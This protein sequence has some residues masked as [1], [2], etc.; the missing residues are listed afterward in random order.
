MTTIRR[1]RTVAVQADANPDLLIIQARGGDGAA[2]GTLLDLYRNYLRLV[3][4]SMMGAALRV[5]LEPSDL[6]QETFLKA[7]RDFAGFQGQTENEFITWL[8]SI[9]ART[10]ADQVKYHRRKRRDLGR[11]ESLDLLLEQSALGL[12]NALASHATSPSDGASRREQAVLWPM[13]SVSFLP[14]IARSSSCAPWSTS[15]LQRSPGSWA[16]P[17]A[18]C[19]CSG[20]ELSKS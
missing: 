5:K 7:H 14:T 6:I 9:M 13:Q 2:L 1:E 4:R 17:Q 18:P 16:D 10:L 8:R 3:A 11:Q 20:R 12:Q 19:G 15:H